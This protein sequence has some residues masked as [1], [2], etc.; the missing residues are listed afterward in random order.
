[1]EEERRV[2]PWWAL[3]LLA[4]ASATTPFIY[5]WFVVFYL[6]FIWLPIPFAVGEGGALIGLLIITVLATVVMIIVSFRL[7]RGNTTRFLVI[8]FWLGY[9]FLV[10]LAVSLIT[11]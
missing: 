8:G 11:A 7:W 3:S 6:P 9:A 2:A 5:L 10:A 1:M 4:L